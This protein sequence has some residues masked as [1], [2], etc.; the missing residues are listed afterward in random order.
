VQWC[1]RQ[2]IKDKRNFSTLNSN[3]LCIS[4]AKENISLNYVIRKKLQM[5]F[6]SAISLVLL[7]ER[8][9]TLLQN[10]LLDKILANEFG[11]SF[12]FNIT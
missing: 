10:Q 7:T 3:T 2:S 11:V 1:S 12:Y 5:N 8:K 6:I 9:E 4:E